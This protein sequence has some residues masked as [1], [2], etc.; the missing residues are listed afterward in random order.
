MSYINTDIAFFETSFMTTKNLRMCVSFHFDFFW[1]MVYVIFLKV[2][3]MTKFW[4][5][6]AE[7]PPRYVHTLTTKI[8]KPV[9]WQKGL[10]KSN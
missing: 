6:K 4:L 7:W 8:H 10:L 3:T 9:V 2:V 1:S 5:W